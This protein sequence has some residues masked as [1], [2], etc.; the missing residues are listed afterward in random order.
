VT[1]LDNKTAAAPNFNVV[2]VGQP[3]GLGY[4]LAIIATD[5]RFKSYEMPVVPNE[6]RSVLCHRISTPPRPL[7]LKHER[8]MQYVHF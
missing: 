1:D 5:Q 3:L 8:A 2:P 4:G 7:R 6:I